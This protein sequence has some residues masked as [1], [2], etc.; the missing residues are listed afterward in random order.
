MLQ[1]RFA[2]NLT[3][4]SSSA[5][6]L[7]LA[8][9]A[10]VPSTFPMKPP[11]LGREAAEPAPSA[12][13]AQPGDPVPGL[14]LPATRASGAWGQSQFARTFLASD[15]PTTP[16]DTGPVAVQED[17]SP[18]PKWLSFGGSVRTR[19]SRLWNQFRP[20]LDKNDQALSIRT[21]LFADAK[22]GG[23]FSLY[24]ELQDARAYLTDERGGVSTIEVNTLTALQAYLGYEQSVEDD[25]RDLRLG[26]QTMDLGGRRLVARNRFRNTIQNY[27]GASA[28]I[29]HG[30][31]EL[32]AFYTLPGLIEPSDV[33]GLV[34]NEYEP[35]EYDLDLQFW[36]AFYT[37]EGLPNNFMLEAYVFGLH[38]SDDEERPT[39]NRQLYTPGF[40]VLRSP[41]A[42]TWDFE[43]EAIGQFGTRRA[44]S[45]ATEDLDV[46]AFFNHT[47]VG[48]TWNSDWSPRLSL[49]LDYGS[50]ESDP[51]DGDWTRFDSLFGPRRT[52]YGPTGIYGLLRREN[53]ISFGPRLG[54]KFS[55]RLDGY[56]S[57]RVNYLAEDTDRFGQG[58]IQDPTG[59]SGDFAGHQIEVRG[60]YWLIPKK[61]RFE[62]GAA[63]FLEGEFL[64]DAP[65]ADPFGDPLFIYSD[66][67]Y[68]F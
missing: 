53:L 17:A 31:S 16:Q 3:A 18:L 51:S 42:G 21:L 20:G 57:W 12:L 26:L 22:L 65:N 67:T 49:E 1:D 29:G 62:L 60:R 40:R 11:K 61:L 28:R 54:A 25:I 44:N 33:Q 4:A 32:F 14:P 6:A 50:G 52:E 13:L 37:L 63:A 43:F 27:L 46:R 5:F 59:D 41:N 24:G 68:S 66:L 23:G 38:E 9:C 58:G 36:G 8:G 34:D 47:A 10:T 19:Y 48:Y 56:V 39:P 2:S 55:E 35:D 45:S 15:L 7:L 64:R 30:D